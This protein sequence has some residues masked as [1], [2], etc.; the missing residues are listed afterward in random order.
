MRY[1]LFDVIWLAILSIVVG[2]IIYPIYL[3]LGSGYPFYFANILF[4]VVT[5]ISLRFLFFLEYSVIRRN[6]IVKIAFIFI[7]PISAIFILDKYILFQEFLDEKGLQS[8]TQNLTH[9]KQLSLS[10]Y[11]RSETIFFA[12]SALISSSAIIFRMIISLWRQTNTSK[13]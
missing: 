13:V 5:G 1:I 2:I 7:I 6:A 9:N 4:I 3:A 12:I 11:I 10:K 8:V